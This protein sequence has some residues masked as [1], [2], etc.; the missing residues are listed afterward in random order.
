MSLTRESIIQFLD[1]ELGIDVTKISDETELLSSGIVDSLA[2][3]DLVTFVSDEAG[4]R[5]RTSDITLE[6]FNTLPAILEFSAAKR[7]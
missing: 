7:R 3:M 4:I 2:V 6:N 1:T 5:V